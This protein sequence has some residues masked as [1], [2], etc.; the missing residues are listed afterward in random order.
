MEE[1]TDRGLAQ[2]LAG[3]PECIRSTIYLADVEGYQYDEIADMLGIPVGTVMSR[4]HRGRLK[5]RRQF[6]A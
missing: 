4:I 6:A 2:A 1:V 3:L 5:L